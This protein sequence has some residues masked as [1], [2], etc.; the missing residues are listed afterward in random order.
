MGQLCETSDLQAMAPLSWWYNW[1]L[2]INDAFQNTSIPN[3]FV[4]M[5]WGPS[6]L[7]ELHRWTPH[8]SST[9]LLGC[10]ASVC[11]LCCDVESGRHTIRATAFLT[12]VCVLSNP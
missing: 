5:V 12:F 8:S 7:S 6:K 11:P 1:G 10:G 2:D 3:E 4:P 9:R